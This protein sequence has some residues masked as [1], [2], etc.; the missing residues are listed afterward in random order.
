MTLRELVAKLV[1]KP[2]QDAEVEYLV[3]REDDGMMVCC[4]L[5]GPTTTELMHVLAKRGAG[6][7]R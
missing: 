6:K 4:D 2:D 7:K 3:Y 5:S 1:A